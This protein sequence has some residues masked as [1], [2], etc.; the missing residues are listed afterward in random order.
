MA[1]YVRSFFI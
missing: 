1:T